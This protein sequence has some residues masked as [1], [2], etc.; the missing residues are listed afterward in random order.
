MI[1]KK[2]RRSTWVVNEED[3][4][5]HDLT[6]EEIRSISD[7]REEAQDLAQDL[8]Q[9][10][11][12]TTKDRDNKNLQCW[13]NQNYTDSTMLKNLEELQKKMKMVI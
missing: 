9:D 8:D 5:H 6:P 1:F 13:S 11:D 12:K 7:Q 3:P 10:Q 2:G 4:L